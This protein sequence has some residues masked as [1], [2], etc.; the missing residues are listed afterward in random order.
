[1]LANSL[2]W[3]CCWPKAYV[4]SASTHNASPFIPYNAFEETC[5]ASRSLGVGRAEG[6]RENMVGEQYGAR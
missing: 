5:P 3:P 6:V 2:R 4:V 1:M